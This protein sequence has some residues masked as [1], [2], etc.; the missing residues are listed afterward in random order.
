MTLVTHELRQGWKSL[1]VWTAAIGFFIAVCVFIFPEM[2]GEMAQAGDI[3][4]S[5]GAFTAAFGMDR[6]NFG[7]LVGYYAIECGNVLGI[8]GALFAALAATGALA[9][10]ERDGTAEFLLTHPISRRRV[11]TE[12]LAALMAQLAALNLIVFLLAAASMSAIGEEI[13]WKVVCLLHLAYFLVQVEIAA[14]CF[15][16]SAFLRRG[17]LGVGLGTAIVLYFLNI[18]ANL[19]EQAEF[20]RYITPFAFAEGA[21][22]VERGS[23]DAGLVLLGMALGAAG[24]A[25]AYWKYTGKDIR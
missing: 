15:G 2:K 6:L 8:G 24:I 21:D 22:I 23:L 10:E 19:T 7:T 18:V 4:A 9:K 16:V 17:G 3:F 14:L 20:L 12:K 11:V 13:P 5:M 1:S 25:A